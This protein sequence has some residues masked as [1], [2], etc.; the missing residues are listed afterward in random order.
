MFPIVTSLVTNR[1]YSVSELQ[2][3]PFSAT[4]VSVSI[5]IYD[6]KNKK[7]EFN[8]GLPFNND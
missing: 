2:Y 4:F 8:S 6:Y 1:E 3:L 5:S 7:I